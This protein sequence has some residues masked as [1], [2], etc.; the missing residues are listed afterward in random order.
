MVMVA[1]PAYASVGPNRV[2][3]RAA[4]RRRSAAALLAAVTSGLAAARDTCLRGNGSNKFFGRS[5][6]RDRLRSA[7]T[8]SGCRETT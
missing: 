4:D 7:T 1:E 3:R 2:D 8:L 5:C 6:R